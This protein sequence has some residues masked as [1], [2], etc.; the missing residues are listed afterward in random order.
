MQCS[1]GVSLNH[2]TVVKQGSGFQSQREAKSSRASKRGILLAL[3]VNIAVDTVTIT[4]RCTSAHKGMLTCR[5]SSPFPTALA[6]YASVAICIGCTDINLQGPRNMHCIAYN[7][8]A[9]ALD[10]AP[11]SKQGG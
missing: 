3:R 4:G 10:P 7:L 9:N 6:L 5:S 2:H 1:G 8:K 11:G